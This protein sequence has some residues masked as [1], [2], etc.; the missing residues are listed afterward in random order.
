MQKWYEDVGHVV[1]GVLPFD[2]LL[3]VREFTKAKLPWPFKGQWPPET[4]RYPSYRIR[5]VPSVG[6]ELTNWSSPYGDIYYNE[7]RLK[8]LR[9]DQLGYAIGQTLRTV[10]LIAWILL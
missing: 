2:L 5:I 1:L 9:R 3:W 7:V 10:G 8:D 6:P 4:N